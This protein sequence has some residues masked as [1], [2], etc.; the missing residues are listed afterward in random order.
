MEKEKV[1]KSCANA[2]T[3]GPYMKSVV[4]RWEP[5]AMALNSTPSRSMSLGRHHSSM[6]PITP[7]QRRDSMQTKA[8][9]SDRRVNTLS[10]IFFHAHE[11]TATQADW[12]PRGFTVWRLSECG[13]M[14]AIAPSTQNSRDDPRCRTAGLHPGPSGR[15]RSR[16]GRRRRRLQTCWEWDPLD[17]CSTRAPARRFG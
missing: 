13:L 2:Q 7:T 5:L 8:L 4:T 11:T 1:N 10:P 14:R 16:V 12:S 9:L 15:W 17:H 3:D 6:F